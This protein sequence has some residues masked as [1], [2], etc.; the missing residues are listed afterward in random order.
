MHNKLNKLF[1]ACVPPTNLNQD[2]DVLYQS[3]SSFSTEG[4]LKETVQLYD[5][6]YHEIAQCFNHGKKPKKKKKT[7]YKQYVT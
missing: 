1:L 5:M 4:M 3:S 2:W 6:N 7:A